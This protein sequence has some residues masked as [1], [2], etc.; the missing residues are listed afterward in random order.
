MV[1]CALRLHPAVRGS[2]VWCGRACWGLGFGCA[3]PL[4][5]EVLGC[6]CARVPV[7][8]GLLHLL[9]RD[10]VRGCVVGAA[11][12]YSWLERRGVYV[13]VRA[14]RLFPAFPGWGVLCGR[15][16]WTPVSAVPRPSW[17]GCWGVCVV[18]RVPRL[19]PPFLGGRLWRGN[20]RVLPFFFFVFGGGACRVLALWCRSLAVPVSGLVVS[21]RP[22]PLFRGCVA[23]FFFF[24]PALCVSACFGC[25]LSRWAAAPC[26]VLL[27]L[28]GWFP[29]APL[30]GPVFSAFWEGGWAASC[31]VGGRFDG[32][33]PPPPVFVLGGGVCLFLPLPSLGWRTHWSA[34]SVVFRVAVGGCIFAGR[35]PAP[36]V[37]WVL[38]TL[39]SAPLPAGLGS[40]SAGGAA[41]P[42]G[43]VWLWVRGAWVVRVLSPPRCR[44]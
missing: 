42:G 17:L 30:G 6:V 32:C 37:R 39:G 29:C 5:W 26:L 20:V 23:G 33:A 44:F 38:Y 24:V 4:L 8:R 9:V 12:R 15:A 31:D 43:F 35:V 27:V 14:P 13:F 25:P 11:P 2:V 21:V 28:A 16:C 7:P 41:A 1:V 10:A 22:S 36:W 34:F 18:V 19:P 3:P 40:G